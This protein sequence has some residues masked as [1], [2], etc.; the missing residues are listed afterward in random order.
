MDLLL[1]VV[2][3]C[4]SLRRPSSIFGRFLAVA[5][6]PSQKSKIDKTRR[7]ERAKSGKRLNSRQRITI[8]PL[9]YFIWRLATRE[10]FSISFSHLFLSSRLESGKKLPPETKLENG[11][12]RSKAANAD[13]PKSSFSRS[14]AAVGRIV[15]IVDLWIEAWKL[16][17]NWEFEF[18]S[19]HETNVQQ[20]RNGRKLF[21]LLGF[22]QLGN[23]GQTL[24]LRPKLDQLRFSLN[25]SCSSWRVQQQLKFPP[26]IVPLIW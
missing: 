20:S 7:P 24:N 25:W 1:L 21:E 23:N 17:W 9:K 12:R 26:H 18:V 5:F 16:P 13:L 11:S 2:H 3:P 8:F 15:W 22:G 19:S 10:P 14:A 6:K 4:H